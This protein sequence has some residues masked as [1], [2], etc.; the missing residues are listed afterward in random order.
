LSS[1]IENG[2]ENTTW[3]YR[4]YNTSGSPDGY[5]VMGDNSLASQPTNIKINVR[6]EIKCDLDSATPS[7]IFAS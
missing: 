7:S 5:V 4:T 3:T 6:L 1:N 2:T